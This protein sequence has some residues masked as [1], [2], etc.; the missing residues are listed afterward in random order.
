MKTVFLGLKDLPFH[1]TAS[2]RSMLDY[3]S[4]AQTFGNQWQ[5][6]Q[7]K[8]GLWL[9]NTYGRT[10]WFILM[11]SVLYNWELVAKFRRPLYSSCNIYYRD[12]PSMARG[13]N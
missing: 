1:A 13:P 7:L 8:M 11:S 9:C 10:A 2:L 4:S 12:T 6:Q 5:A 3:L